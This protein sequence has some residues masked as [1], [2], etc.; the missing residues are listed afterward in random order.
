MVK[1]I[2]CLGDTTMKDQN[3]HSKSKQKS[4][5]KRLVYGFL[6]FLIGMIIW[7]FLQWLVNPQNN[8]GRIF[9]VTIWVAITGFLI[10]WW[11]IKK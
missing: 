10:Y 2:I 7:F 8:E 1:E 11:A 6:A 9:I 3:S 5:G 4:L